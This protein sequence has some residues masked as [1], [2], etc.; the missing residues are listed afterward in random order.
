M[1]ADFRL[2]YWG[3]AVSEVGPNV[4]Q[5]K[6]CRESDERSQPLLGNSAFALADGSIC[7]IK[8]SDQAEIVTCYQKQESEVE[9]DLHPES[10]TGMD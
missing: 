6:N 1:N 5:R 9:L 3:S 7:S 4:T 8:K 10:E 2:L